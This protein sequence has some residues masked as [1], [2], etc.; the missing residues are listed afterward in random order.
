[1]SE[2]T[3]SDFQVQ[4]RV[5]VEVDPALGTAGL[6]G[7]IVRI[8]PGLHFPI[9]VQLDRVGFHIYDAHQ[10]IHEYERPA[11]PPRTGKRRRK[12]TV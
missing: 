9:H 6:H 5:I 12:R 8:V 3:P 4:G 10:L 1:M 2:H 7:T 11:P